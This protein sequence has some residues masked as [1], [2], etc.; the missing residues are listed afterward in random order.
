MEIIGWTGSALVV[1]LYGLNSYQKIRSDSLIFYAGN[2]VGGILLIV[3]SWYKEAAPNVFINFVW[4]IIAI[5]AA[6]RMLSGR[7]SDRQ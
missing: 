7:K 1:L 4:V 6:I 3:Y 2:I 5:P